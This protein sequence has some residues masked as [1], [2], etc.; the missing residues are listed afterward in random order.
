MT[1]NVSFQNNNKPASCVFSLHALGFHT[2]LR[3]C[4][5]HNGRLLAAKKLSQPQEINRN[6]MKSYLLIVLLVLPTIICV[7]NGSKLRE[8]TFY[9]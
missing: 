3:F 2:F 7:F 4:Y 6:T 8:Q 5:L 9:L 1:R